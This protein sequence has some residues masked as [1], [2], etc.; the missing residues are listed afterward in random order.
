LKIIL[1]MLPKLKRKKRHLNGF[2]FVNYFDMQIHSTNFA[3]FVVWFALW[4]QEEVCHCIPSSLENL[5]MHTTKEK[6]TCMMRWERLLCMWFFWELER[7]CLIGE[8][9][10]FGCFLRNAKLSEFES[11]M[12]MLFWGKKSPGSTRLG[13]ANWQL[14]LQGTLLLCRMEWETKLDCS[15]NVFACLSVEWSW[16]LLEGGKWLWWFFL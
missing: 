16:D 13:Q 6:N 10:S 8:E 12:W 3:F 11:T 1:K 7:A 2:R 5:L 4:L 9:L 15:F 14:E